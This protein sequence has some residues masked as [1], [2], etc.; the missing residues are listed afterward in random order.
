MGAKRKR[1]VMLTA[2]EVAQRLEAAESSIRIWAS[3]GR[4]PGAYVERPQVGVPYWQIPES[5]VDG[6]QKEKPG[7]KPK[8]AAKPKVT[9]KKDGN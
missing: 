9:R 8:P 5:A 4:F 2:R 3:R 1:E 6:F 7:P